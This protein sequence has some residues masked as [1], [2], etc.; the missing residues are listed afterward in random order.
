MRFA[1]IELPVGL[2]TTAFGA[3][4]CGDL[5]PHKK[6]IR[7]SSF[8]ISASRRSGGMART[9]RVRCLRAPVLIALTSAAMPLGWHSARP[10]APL[11]A[12]TKWEPS[13]LVSVQRRETIVAAAAGLEA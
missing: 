11:P 3:P 12:R 13:C 8:R 9:S 7:M 1:P 6:S 10:K 4:C 2:V 5:P